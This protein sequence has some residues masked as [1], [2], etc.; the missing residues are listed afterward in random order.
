MEQKRAASTFAFE[1]K[2][3]VM[4]V[5]A[6]FYNE[7]N[8]LLLAGAKAVLDRVG[9]SYEV[10]T[11]PGALEIPAAIGY[12]VKSMNFDAT[13]RRFEG[14]VAL[15]AVIKGGTR[16]DEIVGDLSA[17]GLQELALRHTLAIGNGI[18]TCNDMP[19]AL[20]RADPTRMDKGGG[21]TE[22]C[23]R[24]IEL[25]HQFRLSPKRRWVAR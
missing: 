6:R 10:I 8:D 23:L 9:A 5:E 2:P 21:A 20:E 3:H 25:K 18:I 12:A 7:I 19:Q 15:G 1:E 4:V 16:H 17:K 13:R 11:V 14:Y 24:M 22:A